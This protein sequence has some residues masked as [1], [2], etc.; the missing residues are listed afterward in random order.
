MQWGCD[1]THLRSM[2][3]LSSDLTLYFAL[4]APHP[5]LFRAGC[6]CMT[7]S[8]FQ[9]WF[10]EIQTWKET[11]RKGLDVGVVLLPDTGG[12]PGLTSIPPPNAFSSI[13]DIWKA[14]QLMCSFNKSKE[15]FEQFRVQVLS[16]LRNHM[17]IL[18]YKPEKCWKEELNNIN[19]F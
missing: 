11:Y 14:Q 16:H 9:I 7:R 12:V 1:D 5:T 2:L 10:Q 17:K 15:K 6:S 8:I 18:N 3:L 19:K 4:E 13:S